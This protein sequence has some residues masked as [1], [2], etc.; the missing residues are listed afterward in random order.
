MN[1]RNLRTR[2]WET[3]RILLLASLGRVIPMR[4]ALYIPQG[5]WHGARGAERRTRNLLGGV[6]PALCGDPP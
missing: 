4:S 3:V 6:S 1:R 2:D 5:T